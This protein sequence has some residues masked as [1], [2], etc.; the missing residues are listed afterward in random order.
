MKT[1]VAQLLHYHFSL[2]GL[3]FFPSN[4]AFGCCDGEDSTT[5]NTR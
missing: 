2:L 3:C 5:K 1:T 4:T